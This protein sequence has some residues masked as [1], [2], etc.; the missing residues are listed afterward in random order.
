MRKTTVYLPEELKTELA[1]T[2]AE[3]GC[4]EA[5]L[6]REGVRLA[7][8]QREPPAPRF[9]IIDSGIPDLSERVD[10]YLVGFGER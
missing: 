2:A 9:G 1:R 3:T 8:A 5:E 4:S 7:I 10:E 6:I